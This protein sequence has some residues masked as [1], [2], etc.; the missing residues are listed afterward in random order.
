[1]LVDINENG[2][3]GVQGGLGQVN[4][5]GRKGRGGDGEAG[6]AGKRVAHDGI[7]R[8]VSARLSRG[9]KFSADFSQGNYNFPSRKERLL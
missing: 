1:M 9:S 7:F 3:T 4:A 5:R 8:R 6:R 2:D